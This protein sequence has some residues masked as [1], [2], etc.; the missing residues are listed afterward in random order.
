M[1]H[2]AMWRTAY[3]ITCISVQPLVVS[4]TKFASRLN[5][6]LY[7]LA[8]S[9]FGTIA[10]C[11]S[12]SLTW[13][14]LGSLIQAVGRG[15]IQALALVVIAGSRTV[16]TYVA[17]LGWATGTA[18]GILLGGVLTDY[19]SWRWELCFCILSWVAG[20]CAV[21]HAESDDSSDVTFSEC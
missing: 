18:S 19:I 1:T 16:H 8:L 14:L 5:L 2:T 9:T 20:C 4:S 6:L 21:L 10:Y 12:H 11:T 15:G 13:I 7:T 17:Q 3:L